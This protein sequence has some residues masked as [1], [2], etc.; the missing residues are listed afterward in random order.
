F[1]E[2]K[3]VRL[4][5]RRG[6]EL[7]PVFP[8]LTEELTQQAVD[9]MVLDGEIVAFDADGKPSFHAL[10]NRVHLETERDR[11]AAHRNLPVVFFCFDLLYFGG[12]DLRQSPYRE[13][14]RYLSQCLLPSPRVQ[15]VHA[16]EEGVALHQAAIASGFEGV[17][18]KHKNSRYESGR[19]S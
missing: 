5:S 11:A 14:R 18:G 4:R 9:G 7:G 10:Q 6:L 3:K 15:L 16:S 19:R 1:I 17:L 13:R 8:A 2:G 12:I